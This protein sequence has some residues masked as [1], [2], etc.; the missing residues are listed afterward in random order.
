MD[1]DLDVVLDLDLDFDL[2]LDQRF[3]REFRLRGMSS[4]IDFALWK[5][6]RFWSRSRSRTKTK[7]KSRSRSRSRLKSSW[8][9]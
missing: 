9:Q 7:S 8:V 5:T 4:N 6:Y 1:F 3:C 2:D